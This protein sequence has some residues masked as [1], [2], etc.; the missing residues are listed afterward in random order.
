MQMQE[1]IS[2]AM[3]TNM[4]ENPV[5]QDNIRKLEITDMK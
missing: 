3:N 4:F 2:P 5:V 1:I